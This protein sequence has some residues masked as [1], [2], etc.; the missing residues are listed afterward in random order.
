M[1][2]RNIET[3]F[4]LSPIEAERPADAVGQTNLT[5]SQLAMWMA[6][7][8]QPE[9]PLLNLAALFI[10]ARELDPQ[11]FGRAF[12][13]L[14]DSSDALR[15]VFEEEDGTP[16]QRVKTEL[17]F[18]PDY[19]DFSGQPDPEAALRAWADARCRIL[20]NLTERLFDAALIKLAD[21]CYAWYLNLHHLV[22]DAWAISLIVRRVSD[23]YQQ[24]SN[25]GAPASIALPQFQEHVADERAYL[26]TL[27][28]Q[29]AREYWAERLARKPDPIEFYGRVPP[30]L[31]TRVVRVHRQ[32]GEERM[33]QLRTL[34]SR[35][36]LS[37]GWT[38][39]TLFNIFATILYAYLARLSGGRTLALGMAVHNRHSAAARETIGSLMQVLLL[40]VE[41][42]ADETLLSLLKKVAATMAGAARHSGYHVRNALQQKG[43][44]VFLNYLK[45]AICDFAGE[46]V[47]P[48]WLHPGAGN[49]TLELQVYDFRQKGELELAFDFDE[50]VFD[51]EQRGLA[52]EHFMQVLDSFLTDYTQP[53]SSVN[54]L[55]PA[56]RRRIL[57]DFNRTEMSV[58]ADKTYP[59]LFEEQAE[60]TPD[61]IAVICGTQLVTYAQLNARANRLAHYLKARG[62]GPEQVIA[63]LDRRGID[64]LT[65]I[66][67]VMKTGGAYLPLNPNDPAKR[68]AQLL[69]QSRSRLVLAAEEFRPPLSAA[70]ASLPEAARPAVVWLDRTR[71]SC[72]Y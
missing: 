53:L 32:I 17:R 10:V 45:T 39:V 9:L 71:V 11:R 18:T 33:R 44:D 52:V 25:D 16:R 23:L 12:Q 8:L 15:T 50:E 2:E 27:R 34:A 22:T 61:A 41:V 62:G 57:T 66:I 5:Q 6:Q 72:W 31:T 24:I 19:L 26:R 48:V 68:H 43:Y 51:A 54:L 7:Q 69:Q 38:D 70:V 63:L 36:E 40:Q 1:N 47:T 42:G 49:A 67:A 13:A 14:I 3:I 59:R 60:R 58:P 55:T 30:P 56:E 35:E 29:K 64:L 28:Y 37:A 20:F 65:A 4:E 21:S 46:P